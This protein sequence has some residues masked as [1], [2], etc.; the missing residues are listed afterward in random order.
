M[1]DSASSGEPVKLI[2]KTQEELFMAPSGSPS[3]VAT[4]DMRT[5]PTVDQEYLLFL[6]GRA[7]ETR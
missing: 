1:E 2:K 3:R 6:V 5:F 7:S 4:W